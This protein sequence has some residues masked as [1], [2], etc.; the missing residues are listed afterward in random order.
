[1]EPVNSTLVLQGIASDDVTDVV[2]ADSHHVATLDNDAP[3]IF[4][5]SLAFVR[6]VHDARTGGANVPDTAVATPGTSA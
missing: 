3:T 2:L 6:R 4:T 1:V 5:D